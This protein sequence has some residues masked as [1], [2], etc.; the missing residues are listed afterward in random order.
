MRA[1]FFLVLAAVLYIAAAVDALAEF[2][3]LPSQNPAGLIGES[4]TIETLSDTFTVYG[5]TDESC[6]TPAAIQ[7]SSTPL[8]D[9][10]CQED[11]NQ[12]HP[13]VPASLSARIESQ[14]TWT[15]SG[16]V[17]NCSLPAI[18]P[19]N[20]GDLRSATSIAVAAANRNLCAARAV[21]SSRDTGT[22]IFEIA[23][24]VGVG[25]TVAIAVCFLFG[26]YR[27]ARDIV[28]GLQAGAG[29]SASVRNARAGYEDR[30]S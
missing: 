21:V 23:G 5:A 19:S 28:Y 9:E 26:G 13:D 17:C 10:S 29:L 1:S 7:I 2:G 20:L 3:T 11:W 18:S 12:E 25:L 6:A 8:S 27:I 30:N 16:N 15:R 24:I 4:T 14:C 22:G